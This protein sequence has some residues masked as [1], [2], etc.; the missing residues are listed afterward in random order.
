MMITRYKLLV[1]IN[2]E[3]SDT[4]NI[5]IRFDM[6]E[7]H[8]STL[9]DQINQ[10]KDEK[11]NPSIRR[12]IALAKDSK[13]CIQCA[14]KKYELKF[15]R[16]YNLCLDCFTDNYGKIIFHAFP[17]EYYGGH[18]VYLSGGH[19]GDFQSGRLILT[20]HYLIFVR[21]HKDP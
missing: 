14:K 4:E 7:G 2:L 12:A 13:L 15:S 16:N 5:S 21:E 8:I 9:L 3:R 17:A 1:K 11:V 18:K 10:F 19:S 6:D 20:E